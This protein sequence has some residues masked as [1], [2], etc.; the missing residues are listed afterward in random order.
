MRLF[1]IGY[2]GRKPSDFVSV[3]NDHGIKLVVDVRGRPDRAHLGSFAKAKTPDKGIQ[4]LLASG[5]I[6]YVSIPEL[7][8]PFYH[9]DDW[10]EHYQQLFAKHGKRQIPHLLKLKKRFA[11][12][13][14]EKYV[15]D[16]HRQFIA[17]E[18]E[19]RGCTVVHIE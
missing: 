14:A 1:T 18:L 11:L 5:G 17:T 19:H 13:C 15:K 10:V 12:M 2:G 8:N 9:E 7:G 4:K 3:L 6:D 16:C